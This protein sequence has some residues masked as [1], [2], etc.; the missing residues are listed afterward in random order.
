VLLEG[1]AAAR[2]VVLAG[3]NPGY[4]AVMQLLPDQLFDPTDTKNFAVLLAWYLDNQIGRERAMELQRQ[5]VARYDIAVV[6][7]KL[8]QT[9]TEALQSRRQS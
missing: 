6:G 3:N 5:Y 2:G 4:A 8:V 9:Y 7:E 1:M